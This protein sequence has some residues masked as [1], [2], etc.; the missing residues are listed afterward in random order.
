[1]TERP[2]EIPGLLLALRSAL[3]SQGYTYARLGKALHLSETSVKRLFSNQR[4]S[5]DR[6]EQI[7][8][9]LQLEF[10][11]L[12]DLAQHQRRQTEQL[13][14]EQEQQIAS[15]PALLLVAVAVLGHWRFHELL[16]YY[17]FEHSTLIQLLAKLDRLKLID[18]LPGNRIRLRISPRFRWQ[19]DGPVMQLF[20]ERILTE[21]FAARFDGPQEQLHVQNLMLSEASNRAF[22]D[23][24]HRATEELLR[25]QQQ[26]HRLPLA[27]RHGNTVIL[28]IRRWQYS[29]FAQRVTSGVSEVWS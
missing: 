7:L 26:D 6:L 12:I 5:L 2:S 8:S 11:D 15:D 13:S 18:L 20:R 19:P 24:M 9:I 21:Y 3:K 4:L 25:L 23:W 22:Q 28:A 10:S 1:M 27:Q 14:L 16:E 17:D 29:G